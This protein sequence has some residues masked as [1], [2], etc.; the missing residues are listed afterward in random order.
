MVVEKMLLDQGTKRTDLS[1]E[2]FENKVWD[3]KSE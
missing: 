3:W 1:R 2:Q